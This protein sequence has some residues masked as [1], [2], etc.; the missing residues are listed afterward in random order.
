MGKRTLTKTELKHAIFRAEYLKDHNGTRAAIAAGY[1]K[2]SAHV[3]A[4]RLIRNPKVAQSIQETIDNYA[5]TAQR[6]MHETACCAFSN[7]RNYVDERGRIRPIRDLTPDQAAAVKEIKT[8]SRIVK[9]ADDATVVEEETTLKLVDKVR[10]LQLLARHTGALRENAQE[11]QTFILII[12]KPRS[13]EERFRQ[14]QEE[15][16]KQQRSGRL[17]PAPNR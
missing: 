8:K 11:Q 14:L 3:T 12:D 13:A 5:V 9:K 10:A 16:E 15:N 17:L 2:R 1:S 4:S 6:T 7:M